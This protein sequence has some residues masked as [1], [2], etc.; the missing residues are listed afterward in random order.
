MRIRV[1][2]ISAITALSMPLL[3][4][5]AHA[6]LGHI[7]G[8][9]LGP[10]GTPIQGIQV[11]AYSKI[12]DGHDP[13]EQ[14]PDGSTTT[15]VD[16]HYTLSPSIYSAVV[17]CFESPNYVHECYGDGYYPPS[18]FP[19]RFGTV[20]NV[21]N[22]DVSGVDASLIVGASVSGTVTNTQTGQPVT[23]GFV[24]V[25]TPLTGIQQFGHV[26]SAVTDGGGHFSIDHI[27]PA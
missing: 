16:G 20:L 13:D 4:A 6:A 8:T 9:V 25:T 1:L 22:G 27:E 19:G 14:W 12:E 10:G 21:G 18:G 17:V 23:N 11:N 3:A 7:T 5:P 24:S 15:D 26:Y 2:L